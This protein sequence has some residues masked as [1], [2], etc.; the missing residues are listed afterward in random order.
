MMSFV[1]AGATFAFVFAIYYFGVGVS[2]VVRWVR[3]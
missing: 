2:R 1:Y 3:R